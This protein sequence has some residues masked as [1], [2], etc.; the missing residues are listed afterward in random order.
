MLI[1]MET[2]STCDFPKGGG[3]GPDSCL[4]VD[5][6]MRTVKYIYLSFLE[7]VVVKQNFSVIKM[8]PQYSITDRYFMMV[9]AK[10]TGM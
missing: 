3:G 7:L 1:L 8:S 5:P 6:P 10:L 4:P 9:Y 2:Y